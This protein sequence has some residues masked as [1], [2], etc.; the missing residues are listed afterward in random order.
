MTQAKTLKPGWRT[1][2]FGDVVREVR[3]ATKDP[4]ADGI[5]RVVGL[6][7]LDRESLPLRRWDDLAELHDGTSFTRTFKAGQVMFGKRRAYQRKVAVPDFDGICSGDILVFEPS[8]SDLLLEFLPYVVQSD[9]FFEH[10]LGTSAGSLSPRTKWQELAKYEFVLPPLDEQKRCVQVLSAAATVVECHSVAKSELDSALQRF[11][12][13]RFR[14]WTRTCVPVP[15]TTL[16]ALQ[17]GRQK[18]PKYETGVYSTPYVRVGNIGSL[19]V[20]LGELE[21]MDFAP[22][23]RVKY[24]LVQGD[25]LITEGDIVSPLNVGRSAVFDG[26]ESTVCFQNT[27]IR[28]RPSA[29]ANPTFVMGLLEGARLEG[30]FAAAASTTTVSHLGLK[31]LSALS[32]PV[33]EDAERDRFA[34]ALQSHLAL[35][36]QIVRCTGTSRD[37]ARRMAAEMLG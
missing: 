37:L 17:L 14:H 29:G 5:E 12:V 11:I 9:G 34:H 27:L 6:D 4:V 10:A 24:G 36:E 18:A 20:A 7:H 35:R 15:I 25:V 33:P 8:T 22:E 3:K 32:L 30:V 21:E 26:A 1:V 2:K 28:L 13:E 23:D 16:G 19:E 31:R